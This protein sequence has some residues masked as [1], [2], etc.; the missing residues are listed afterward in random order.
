[1]QSIIR[2]AR[3]TPATRPGKKPATIA[4][5]GKALQCSCGV[6]LWVAAEFET[7]VLGTVVA[8]LGA[9]AEVVEALLGAEDEADV[10]EDEI[11]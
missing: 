7:A 4:V 8:M 10:A 1:M 6:E 5:A 2:T 3:R 11:V 9:F